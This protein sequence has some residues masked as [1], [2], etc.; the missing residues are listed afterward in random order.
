MDRQ[1][2]RQTERKGRK[3]GKGSNQLIDSLMFSLLADCVQQVILY[4]VVTKN[5][6]HKLYIYTLERARLS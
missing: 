2:D 6:L 1:T 4:R 3:E 5:P